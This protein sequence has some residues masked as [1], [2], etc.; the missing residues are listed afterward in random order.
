M[1]LRAQ[2]VLAGVRRYI[3]INRGDLVRHPSG[4]IATHTRPIHV[5]SKKGRNASRGRWI[6]RHTGE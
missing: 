3:K 5:P 2:R 4:K 1:N 6:E